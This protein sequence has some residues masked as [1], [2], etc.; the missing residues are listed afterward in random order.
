MTSFSCNCTMTLKPRHIFWFLI[1]QCLVIVEIKRL[2]EPCPSVVSTEELPKTI[3]SVR[4]KVEMKKLD[5]PYSFKFITTCPNICSESPIFLVI[6]VHSK[7]DHFT[8]RNI[9]R[10]TWASLK[11]YHFKYIATVF[12]LGQSKNSSLQGLIDAEAEKHGDIIQGQFLDTYRNMTHKHLTG[13]KWV[14]QFCSQSKFVL[15]VDDDTFVNTIR[16]VHFLERHTDAAGSVTLKNAIFCRTLEGAVPERN[17]TNKHYVTLEEYS[18][19]FYP[20][21][22]SGLAYITTTEVVKQLHKFS[23]FTN[24]FWIDDIYITGMVAERINAARTRPHIPFDFATGMK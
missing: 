13:L 9:I 21:Y 8:K 12:L 1:L 11:N 2:A 4:A 10:D 7:F 24:F 23:S 22:C 19:S 15:K 20:T 6:F 5:N 3:T 17:K 18:A 14:T 16:L